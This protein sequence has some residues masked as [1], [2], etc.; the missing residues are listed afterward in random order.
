MKTIK[1]LSS[2][3]LKA[4]KLTIALFLVVQVAAAQSW[5][6]A[7]WDYRRP[8]T[9]SNTGGQLTD[10][11]VKVSL[12]ASFPWSHVSNNGSDLRFTSSDG[13]TELSYWLESWTYNSS[14][15]V[16]VKVPT[17]AASPA[18]TTVFLYYGN[19]SATAGSSGFNTF[20]FFDD[21]ESGGINASRWS[22]SG[23]TWTTVTA[24]QQNGSSSYVAQG[25]VTVGNQVLQSV[26]FTGSDYVA[27]VY[28]RQISGFN[29][30]LCT[31]ATGIA[32]Y[33]LTVL[34]DNHDAD[35]NLY[36]FEWNPTTHPF[37][38]TAIG[39]ISTNTWYKM[40]VRVGGSNINV[41][42]NDQLRQTI[43]NSL[44]PTGG[45]ALWLQATETA[46]Y[47]DLRVRKY[48]VAEPSSGIGSEQNQYPP[49]T[50][51]YTHTDVSCYGASDGSINLSVTGGSGVYTYLWTPGNFATEDLSGLTAGTY[52]VFVD[53]GLGSTGNQLVEITQPG[54]LSVSH[55]ITVPFNCN[56]GLAGVEITATGGTPPYSG[57]GTFQQPDGITDY[58]VTDA[59]GCTAGIQVNVGP[60]SSW[61]DA[62][63]EFRE[64]VDIS[65]PGG[66]VLND[67]Q[68][69]VALGRTFDF[70]NTNSDGSD[71]RFTTDDGI[72]LL[73][74]WIE[75]WDNTNDTATIWVKVP[76]I[77][78]PGSTI[79]M[80]YGNSSA[81]GASQGSSTFRFFE[82]FEDG[83][84]AVGSWSSSTAHDWKYSMI[85]QEGALYYSLIRAQNGWTIES[86]DSEIAAE[87]NY[88]HS[89]TNS[90]GTVTGLST[91][92]I[93]C[94]GQVLSNLA[95]GY[96]Y[97]RDSNAPLALRCYHDMGLVYGYM[98]SQWSIPTTAPDYSIALIGFSN[99]FKAFTT[100]GAAD[101]A[102]AVQG[103]VEDY[104]SV[105]TQSSGGWTAQSGVQDHLKR[106][107]GVLLAYDVTGDH[108][109]LDRVRANMDWILVNRFLETNG[110]LTWTSPVEGGEFYECHQQWFMVAVRMLYERDNTYNYLSQ[111]LAA[112]H[113]LT[114]N[115]YA[116]IDM[117]VHNYLSQNAFFSYRQLLTDGSFQTATFKGSYEIGTALWGMALNYDWVSDYQSAH[118]PQRFNYLDEMVKQIKKAPA[119]AGYYSASGNWVRLLNWTGTTYQP[120]PAKW[121]RVGSPTVQLVNDGGNNVL[122]LRG[123]THNDLYATVDR[124]FDN[125]VFDA[126]VNMTVDLNGSSN[127]EVGFHYSDINNR[128]FTLMRGESQNDLFMRR[129]QGGIS[130]I[131]NSSPF[132]Y[133]A[134]IYYNYKMVVNGNVIRLFLND[135]P[136]TNYTDNGNRLTGGFSIGNYAGTAVYYDDIRVREYAAIEPVAVLGTG[137]YLPGTW[138]GAV[139]SDWSNPL[140]WIGGLPGS[141]SPAAIAGTPGIQPHITSPVECFNLTVAS[142]TSLV[143]DPSG[144]L[145]VNGDLVTNG[146]LTISSTLASSGS[147]IVKGTST[148]NITYNRQLQP[149]PDASRNFHLGAAP[150]SN[151]SETNT[152]KISTVNGWDE[153]TG[154]WTPVV[155]TAT[156]PGHGYN[157]RQTVSSDGV[158]SF[159][160]PLVDEDMVVAASSPYADAVG[161]GDNYFTRSFV[162]GRSLDN[163]GGGGWN[164]LGNPYTSAIEVQQFIDANFSETPALS[165]L[166]PNY[167]ALYL[168][169]GT[170]RRYYYVAGS[171]GWPSGTEL[172]ETHIQAGQGFFALAMNDNSEFH[173]TQAMQEHMTGTNMLKSAGA[174]DNR[175]PGLQLKVAHPAG[176]VI[177]TVVYNDVMTEGVDPGYDIGL[178]K[179]GQAVEV[180]TTLV[181]KDNGVNFA[182]QAL[183]VSG[184]DTLT[185]SLGIDSEKGGEVI[186]SAITVPL[187][188]MKFWLE[189]RLTGTFTDLGAGSYTVILP[190]KTYGTGRFFL[191]SAGS[192]TDIDT[193]KEDINQPAIRIW[194]SQDK[195]IIKG[196]VS[197]RATAEVYDFRGSK[198][199]E[200]L[201]PD[202][203]L[204]T[205]ALPSGSH[206]V[207]L[208][209]VT[210]G[211]KVYTQKVV[212]R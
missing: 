136:V 174:T 2:F 45:V 46:Q 30:G 140:N 180:Y 211:G 10:F 98:A 32:N 34:Y 74:F 75:S 117:Y 178:F 4:F 56:T 104:V 5:F 101:T 15:T 33:Y 66:T 36:T 182:R 206:G 152:G 126:K 115:N 196:V 135:A 166:D 107:F 118:S 209:R 124:S 191:K 131:D 210:D 91:E 96:L 67:Y 120:D 164:L 169:D 185:V 28:G 188:N 80:Y 26:G 85:M 3:A 44:H 1:P 179:S 161:P 129:I 105:F 201:L 52:S 24:T 31:R 109:Y 35:N 61:Y 38:A 122:S 93:Y 139:S 202:E 176:E 11:Q 111:G 40:S 116:G 76:E 9:I 79:Y 100:Y 63:W 171:T 150:V 125:F 192:I 8:V 204:N 57:T 189:D 18:L 12:D 128:Y 41:S 143:I 89:M 13:V 158:I 138:T 173:F 127:P 82:D 187:G 137:L 29:W 81:S 42:I 168:F 195:L 194:T 153:V 146:V 154:L 21:F 130:Y 95:L 132:N 6:N 47:N 160:G 60:G 203:A 156:L 70:S 51:V 59:H 92:P 87:F 106:N 205:V 119:E 142:G 172:D 86:L 69:K 19:S 198:I 50:V 23:G 83:T 170:S 181:Q 148:G 162:A 190:A 159:T 147:L 183:P 73:S 68:V 144:A 167:V 133:T 151:N 90:N 27:E 112:W 65:N 114:D 84:P 25:T 103:I 99:A 72:T 110:G 20:D 165:Q 175:W 78:D 94:Y 177:T 48:A 134:G 88:M 54:L 97:Y 157:F 186:F 64:P 121:A 155:F 14:A 39:T 62:A 208:V 123:A 149:G 77:I 102:A 55:S 17:V 37:W 207:Y 49:L 43:S 184:A 71:I 193:P 22:A 141:C 7:G 200:T 113:F 145:T 197:E 16:W 58:T 108:T 199:L 212:L 163:F 53:D